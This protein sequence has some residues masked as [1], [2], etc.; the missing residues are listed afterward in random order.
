M[1]IAI[2]VRPG[3]VLHLSPQNV[4]KGFTCTHVAGGTLDLSRRIIPTRQRTRA[5]NAAASAAATSLLVAPRA[6]DPGAGFWDFGS[7]LESTSRLIGPGP[8][9]R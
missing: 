4:R 8:V 7:Q 5:A 6:A 9:E 1:P 2:S 3:R